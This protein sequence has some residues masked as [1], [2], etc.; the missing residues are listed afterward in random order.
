MLL[1]ATP[2]RRATVWACALAAALS[3][4]GADVVTVP[5][6]QLCVHSETFSTAGDFVLRAGDRLHLSR[7]SSVCRTSCDAVVAAGCT[8]TRAGDTF[9]LGGEVRV[10]VDCRGSDPPPVCI[11]HEA[12]CVTGPLAEGE[13]TVTD[14]VRSRSFRVPSVISTR[15]RCTP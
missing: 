8:L 11:F 3:G 2:T 9:R 4:C 7:A 15:M 13:Y 12:T 14:G 6:D 5:L 10:E 1:A